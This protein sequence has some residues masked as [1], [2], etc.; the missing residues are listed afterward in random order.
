MKPPQRSPHPVRP[1]QLVSVVVPFFNEVE[2]VPALRERMSAV[3][4]SINVSSELVLVD[5]GSADGTDRVLREWAAADSRVRVLFLSRNFGHQAALTA[6]LDA[7]R[8]DAVVMIDADLQDP[9]EVIPELLAKHI[10]GYD[11]VYARRIRR[12]GETL[13]KRATAFLFY[14]LMRWLVH[15]DLP[16]DVGDFRLLSRRCL[17]DV[18]RMREAHRFLRGMT[19][20]VGYPQSAVDYVREPRVAGHTKFSLGAMLSFAWTAALSFS[21][22]PLRLTST[23]G[24]LSASGGM[25]Y[26]VYAVIRKL[27]WGDTVKGWTTVIILQAV[28]GG[29]ILLGLGMLGEYVA[30][31]YEQV[32]G[33][34][35]YL[36][37]EQLNSPG[38]EE[39]NVRR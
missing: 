9:P 8:G 5:D 2:V 24:I 14:R 26:G 11:V 28:I 15:P 12:E 20:W 27:F 35:L 19:V 16:T 39:R 37:A 34:P 6:G 3:L 25:L 22:L 4:N 33:R 21:Y 13:F 10:E 32:K 23:I 29:V 38:E 17:N 31:I 18:R 30:R 1:L 36:V 7:A